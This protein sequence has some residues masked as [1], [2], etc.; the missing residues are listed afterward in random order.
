MI[1]ELILSDAA[2]LCGVSIDDVLSK[3]KRIEI[4]RARQLAW[5]VLH[6]KYGWSLSTI[7][8]HT[9]KNHTTIL[10]GINKVRDLLVMHADVRMVVDD[11]T[12]INYAE[13]VRDSKGSNV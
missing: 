2:I 11:L 8:R 5:Y 12:S 9:K 4:V 13:L 3:S 1:Y 7:A 6:K 10:H